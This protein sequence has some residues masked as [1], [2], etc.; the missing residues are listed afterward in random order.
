MGG[1]LAGTLALVRPG[2]EGR[3]HP[4]VQE[5]DRYALL[6]APFRVNIVSAATPMFGA[7]RPLVTPFASDL[8]L[9]AN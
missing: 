2:L 5:A 9:L 7:Y 6:R 3:F 8:V 4:P 1:L